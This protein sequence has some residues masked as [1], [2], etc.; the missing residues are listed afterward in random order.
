MIQSPTS[1]WPA[2][3]KGAVSSLKYLD[4]L[5]NPTYGYFS[6]Q[7]TI[8]DPGEPFN[9]NAMRTELDFD[10]VLRERYRDFEDER[11][12]DEVNE[13]RQ[14]W[15]TPTELFRPY[16][17]EAMARNM[18]TNYKISSY[19]YHDL[20]IYELGAGN[21]TF[22]LNV[23]NYIR[24]M[25]PD[26]YDRTKYKIIEISSNLAKKQQKRLEGTVESQG[27]ASH[28]EIINKSI[29]EWDTYVHAP[30]FVVCLEVI[31][32]F[33]HDLIRYNN[34]AQTLE[35]ASVVIDTKGEFYTLWKPQLDPLVEEYLDVRAAACDFNDQQTLRQRVYNLWS[36]IQ[37]YRRTC[38]NYEYLPTRLLQFF[39]I[40]QTY[41]PSHR[42]LLSDFHTL[43]DT[44]SPST[45]N[46]PV[47]QTRFQR[48]PVPVTTPLVFQ[49]YFDIFF[50]TNFTVMERIYQA[51]TG[52][53]S[54]ASTHEDFMK[55]WADVDACT[56]GDGLSP[57]LTW[58]RN[59]AV[60]TTV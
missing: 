11:D 35:Q 19:P 23:L 58:Y 40:L 34:T 12:R 59:A 55:Q 29:L 13:T 39:T 53:L 27:H 44:C 25:D 15:H 17:A 8:F 45:V 33:A 47:V 50:P 10:D 1:Y 30:C 48:I 6:S 26:V 52:K 36:S 54:R 2:C 16:Y 21:G 14:L 24:D 57:L 60:M 31:D 9:F 28:V 46:A 49:G 37:G 22:M 32:N 3:F 20:I 7:A 51:V 56:C 41:F 18:V 42:L 5:Y 43:P 38:T 4:C